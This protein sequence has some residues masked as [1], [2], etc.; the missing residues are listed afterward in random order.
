MNEDSRKAL[1]N[2]PRNLIS[3]TLVIVLPRRGVLKSCDS[4]YLSLP[5]VIGS[6]DKDGCYSF[7]EKGHVTL[8][9]TILPR[10]YH[11]HFETPTEFFLKLCQVV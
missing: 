7:F 1:H 9:S 10:F 3:P 4:S 2:N 8:F 6:F 5:R 11:M